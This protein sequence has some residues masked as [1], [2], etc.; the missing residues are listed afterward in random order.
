MMTASF[1]PN[2]FHYRQ[3][4]HY[5]VPYHQQTR[6]ST[7]SFADVRKVNH[8]QDQYY[9]HNES[10]NSAIEFWKQQSKYN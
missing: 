10:I 9:Q 2:P 4:N 7:Q 8:Y 3:V 5:Q 1:N 6:S